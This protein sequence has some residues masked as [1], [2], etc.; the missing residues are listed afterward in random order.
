MRVWVN[1][2]FDILHTGHIELL[3]YAK[4]YGSGFFINQLVVGIDSDKRIKELKGENR[5]INSESERKR[6]LEA[7]GVVDC[8]VIF[9][10]ADE[11]RNY[12][13]ELNIDLMFVGEEYK[14]KEVI[15]SENAKRG[16]KYYPVDNRSTTDLIEKIKNL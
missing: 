11:L 13:K 10:T 12:I 2:C 5:P 8:V 6:M 7:I 9:D 3:H 15:G 1:G 4:S 16:V 14:D